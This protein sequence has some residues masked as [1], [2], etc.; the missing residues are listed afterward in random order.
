MSPSFSRVEHGPSQRTQIPAELLGPADFGQVWPFAFDGVVV[1]EGQP[2]RD[3]VEL[4]LLASAPHSTLA[5]G[6]LER[7]LTRQGVGD[8]LVLLRRERAQ[9]DLNRQVSPH[10]AGLLIPAKER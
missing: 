10:H 9:P 6:G 1:E 5:P 3:L 8:G 7:A 2:G 4:T